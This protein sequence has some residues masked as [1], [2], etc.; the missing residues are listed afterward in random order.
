MNTS[1]SD[2]R[3]ISYSKVGHETEKPGIGVIATE[4][5][6]D[7]IIRCVFRARQYGYPVLVT[8]HNDPSLEA[9]SF[10]RELGA[11]I[12]DPEFSKTDQ[13]LTS[14]LSKNAQQAGFPGL[15]I[16]QNVD[17]Y[18][19]YERSVSALTNADSYSISAVPVSTNSR[20]PTVIAIPAYNEEGSIKSIVYQARQYADEV[21][22]VDDGS[23]DDTRRRADEAGAIVLDHGQNRGYGATLK[24]IFREANRRGADPLVILDGDGQHDAN[25]IPKL[26]ATLRESEAELVIGNRFQGETKTDLPLY[27]SL[28]L[29]AVNFLTNVSLGT[30]RGESRIED[31]QSGFRV[32]SSEAIRTLAADDSIGT[33]MDAST[34]ILYHASNHGYRIEEVGTTINYAVE[35]TSSQNPIV[36]G[37]T[38]VR[39]LL[40]L[41][42]R[43]KPITVLGGPGLISVLVGFGFVYWTIRNYVQTETFPLGIAFLASMFILVGIFSCFTAIILHSLNI[44]F[45]RSMANRDRKK[46]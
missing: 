39:N 9:L 2:T 4:T 14:T 46:S 27:R 29:W 18:I 3:G 44:H 45:G 7:A 6:S 11:K 31:T 19:D 22:V 10:A 21:L 33:G 26:L 23:D 35:N 17:E 28:G 42:E 37:Y 13:S 36:H 24:T 38:L 43:Q 1:Q 15:I 16:H 12:V 8:H 40:N 32:Y 30:V 41:I 34:D 25:D 20:S 5:N